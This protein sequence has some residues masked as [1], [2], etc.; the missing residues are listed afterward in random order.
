MNTETQTE[1]PRQRVEFVIRP[2]SKTDWP[3]VAD[4][5]VN[6]HRASSRATKM[7]EKSAFFSHQHRM[8]E[9]L[10]KRAQVR[11]AAPPDDDFTVLGFAVLEEPG[12]VHM[13]YVKAPFR[14]LGLA[15]ALLDGVKLEESTFTCWTR[16]VGEWIYDRFKGLKYNPFAT[17]SS[18]P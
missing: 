4:A 13:V 14:K 2:G 18:N 7:S 17:E 3:M 11:I 1:R 8:V 15:R 16:D 12:V 9:R 5:W 6:T 10:L